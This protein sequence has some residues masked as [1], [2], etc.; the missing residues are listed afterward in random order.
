[1]IPSCQQ[2]RFYTTG[3]YSRI[4]F[5]TR[6]VAYRGRGK[7]IHEFAMNARDDVTKCGPAGRLYKKKDDSDNELWKSLLED[8]E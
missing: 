7:L 5:C 4:G 6:F 8:E 2:C 3:K 1:M